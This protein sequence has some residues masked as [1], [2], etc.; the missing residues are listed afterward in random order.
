MMKYIRKYL[1][2]ALILIVLPCS[3]AAQDWPDTLFLEFDFEGFGNLVLDSPPI[4]AGD[5]TGGDWRVFPDGTWWLQI[6]DSEWPPTSDPNARWDHIFNTYFIHDPGSFSWTATFDNTTLPTKPTW[7]IQHPV[8]GTM[9]G[10]AI[11]V[12]TFS[13]WD[14]DGIL[15][16]EERTFGVFSGTL[17][18]MKFGT[19]NFSKYCGDGSYNGSLQNA[20]PINFAD[21]YVT[22]HCLLDLIDC[23]IGNDETSWS[24]LKTRFK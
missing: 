21:D 12:I 13:D 7:E 5:I 1:F 15:D 3:V 4:Y 24:A 16:P 23:S 11:I 2:L 18:V 17:L 19:G 20:D 22:G 8:N 14:I 10:T 6:D 9:G